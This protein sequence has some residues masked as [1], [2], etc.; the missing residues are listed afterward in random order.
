MRVR[1]ASA[2]AHKWPTGEQKSFR[3]MDL[4]LLYVTRIEK[5]ED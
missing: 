3:V 5:H 2:V 4:V 1:A